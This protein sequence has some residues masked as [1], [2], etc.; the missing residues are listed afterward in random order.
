MNVLN[1]SDNLKAVINHHKAE[2]KRIGKLD[3]NYN[4]SLSHKNSLHEGHLECIRSLRNNGCEI[5]IVECINASSG[6]YQLKLN[7]V[8]SGR[9]GIDGYFIKAANF[10]NAKIATVDIAKNISVGALEAGGII[11]WGETLNPGRE[12][13]EATFVLEEKI[14]FIEVTPII[15]ETIENKIRLVNCGNA[16]I[17]EVVS[18]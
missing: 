7:L 13:A 17:R 6:K 11:Q 16:E 15:Y 10:E 2:G 4:K 9:F 12:A 8:N 1:S 3:I 18:C 14:Y 5:I